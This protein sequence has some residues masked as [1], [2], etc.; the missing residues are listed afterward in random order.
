L[1]RNEVKYSLLIILSTALT[2]WVAPWW[3]L[4]IVA[5]LSTFLFHPRKRVIG[6]WAVICGLMY[7]ACTYYIDVSN[8]QVLSSK[9]SQLFGDVGSAGLITLS[10][11]IGAIIVLIGSMT[12][13]CLKALTKRT[14]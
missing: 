6:L 14:N 3:F 8:N 12:G 10:A 7:L 2:L 13:Y 1:K 11:F 5:V 4:Y 9:I